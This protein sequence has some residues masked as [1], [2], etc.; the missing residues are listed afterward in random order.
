MDQRVWVR[1]ANWRAARSAD[2]PRSYPGDERRLLSSET[3]YG[4]PPATARS[5]VRPRCRSP[6]RPNPRRL[7]SPASRYREG[8]YRALLYI[9]LPQLADFYSAAVACVRSAVDTGADRDADLQLCAH[10]CRPEDE[11]R[12]SAATRR[13]LV[14][15]AAR[16]RR[17]GSYYAVPS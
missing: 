14:D 1:A 17:Q 13:Q 2:P 7:I 9:S 4:A 3:L 5:A 15:P 12:G 16:E 11:G 6:P 8:P 10:Q